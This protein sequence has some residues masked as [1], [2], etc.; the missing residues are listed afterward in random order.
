MGAEG[1]EGEEPVGDRRGFRDGEDAGG[2]G[3]GGADIVDPD[4]EVCERGA[5]GEGVFRRLLFGEPEELVLE[6][7]EGVDFWQGKGQGHPHDEGD[8]AEDLSFAGRVQG[9]DL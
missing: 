2:F 5:V 4:A 9:S 3:G 8:E 7:D 1:V 6:F